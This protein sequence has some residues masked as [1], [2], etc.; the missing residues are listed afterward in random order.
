MWDSLFSN[1][2]NSIFS[3]S[4]LFVSVLRSAPLKIVYANMWRHSRL[5][6]ESQYKM[7]TQLAGSVLG[8]GM[9]LKIR[10]FDV[11]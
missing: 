3:L 4:I 5:E 11:P 10:H 9:G 7:F 8:D 2:T 1:A 6:K